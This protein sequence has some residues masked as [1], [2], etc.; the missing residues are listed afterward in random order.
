[1]PSPCTNENSTGAAR[2]S[3]PSVGADQGLSA[4]CR[5][6]EPSRVR[7]STCGAPAVTAPDNVGTGGRSSTS[8]QFRFDSSR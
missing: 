3:A 6:V 1:M 4:R 2:R 7:P 8:S 5:D